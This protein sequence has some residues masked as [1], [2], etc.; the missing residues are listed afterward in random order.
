MKIYRISKKFTELEQWILHGVDPAE[1][2][3][4]LKPLCDKRR[5]MQA[6]ATKVCE[7]LGFSNN[8]KDFTKN[9]WNTISCYQT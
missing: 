5:V 1:V 3:A 6:E 8:I 7:E 9:D 2:R 4:E